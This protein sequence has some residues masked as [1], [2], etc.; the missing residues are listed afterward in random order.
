LRMRSLAEV[1][2]ALART[3]AL[4]NARAPTDEG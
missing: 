3:I 4:Q 2:T 1:S